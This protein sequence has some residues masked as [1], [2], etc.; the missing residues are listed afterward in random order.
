MIDWR[1]IRRDSVASTMDEIDALGEMG[2]PSGTVVVARE[3]TAGR[4]RAG[5]TWSAPA[6]SGLFVSVLHRTS[7]PARELSAL[8]L[9][10]GLALADA[11]E[12]AAG[13]RCLLK[14]PNDLL[15]DGRKIAGVL[16]ATKLSGESVRFA[17]IGVGINCLVARD[18]LPPG[19]G[20]IC[21]ETGRPVA[22]EE[23]LPKVLHQLE[24]SLDA[25]ER[26]SGRGDLDRWLARAA[27]LGEM[28]AVVDGGIRREGR[29]VGVDPDGALRL[30]TEDGET[31]RVVSG[32][33]TRGPRPKGG[34]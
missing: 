3:Q 1:V 20:S 11:I 16:V 22:P 17:N 31:I 7:L 18:D 21:S 29:F 4:G 32:D 8:P 26:S 6:G 25:F 5:R 34:W 33:L 15:T 23:L 30:R 12:E 19:A 10:V 28:V 14:W 13:L 2:A 24:R 27:F 9:A